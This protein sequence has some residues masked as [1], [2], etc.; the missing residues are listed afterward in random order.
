MS[1]VAHVNGIDVEFS[2]GDRVFINTDL[3]D[4][5]AHPG[6]ANES[7]KYGMTATIQKIWDGREEYNI[8]LEFDDPIRYGHN[9]TTRYGSGI[10]GNDPIKKSNSYWVAPKVVT[11]LFEEG[12]IHGVPCAYCGKI[13]EN[14]IVDGK[15]ICN[16]C[17]PKQTFV[18]E[19]CGDVHDIRVRMRNSQL[20]KPCFLS[21]GYVRCDHCSKPT[22]PS[23]IK[24]LDHSSLCPVCYPQI[25]KPC[26]KCGEMHYEHNLRKV[27]KK[28]I[29]ENCYERD[30]PICG[31]CGRRHSIKNTKTIKVDGAD[32]P[33]CKR[34]FDTRIT[35]CAGCG[36]YTTNATGVHPTDGEEGSIYCRKCRSSMLHKCYLCGQFHLAELSTVTLTQKSGW[37]GDVTSERVKICTSCKENKVVT[38][39]H[40][41]N[42]HIKSSSFVVDGL[43]YCFTCAKVLFPSC[44]YC[45]QPI[46][47]GKGHGT[48]PNAICDSCYA[49]KKDEF[50]HI[51]SAERS[52]WNYHDGVRSYGYKPAPIMFPNNNTDELH[53]GI[54]LEVDGWSGHRVTG[55]VTKMAD[56]VNDR[57][58][59]SYTKNDG[60]LGYG[61]FEIV[62]HPATLDYHVNTLK[63]QWI[64]V[65]KTLRSKGYASHSST[66]CGLHV[67]VSSFPVKYE[68]ENG[69]EKL[70]Y[71]WDHFWPELLK[72][73]RRNANQCSSWAKRTSTL[74]DGDDTDISAI[75]KLISTKSKCR[76]RYVA[77]NLNNDNTIEF[78]LMRGTLN[79]EAFFATLELIDAIVRVSM[80]MS[81]KDIRKM[82]W[83]DVLN[84]IDA[85]KYPHAKSYWDTRK[86]IAS[87]TDKIEGDKDN[88]PLIV[89]GTIESG[90]EES[91][92]IPTAYTSD[93]SI[94]W[95]ASAVI[96]NSPSLSEIIETL[97]S[98]N[99]GSV[100]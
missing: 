68:A 66:T 43:N 11:H 61:G 72:F 18:C 67:H 53:Y 12:S 81:F 42:Y 85:A 15:P 74:V 21:K 41:G 30:Y 86:N 90:V 36:E 79:P 58:G 87:D 35:K 10:Y 75:D 88:C 62:T 84:S 19:D 13:G 20:C 24:I 82:S 3:D 25:A 1:Y 60:S 77:V 22:L 52:P 78:R 59:Y 26:S 51:R 44:S 65:M 5:D 7:I 57:L 38:C 8:G 48:Y 92:P 16:D 80:A 54:E 45:G 93:H 50:A 83:D 98:I 4:R 29:C 94:S 63:D 40:C 37:G 69:V 9:L 55:N 14:K 97:A 89:S 34:C 6:Y 56:F 64:D 96:A 91:A 76:E 95:D 39:S 28:T 70:L 32:I 49:I 17:L 71:I 100:A 33:V 2:I 23:A 46:T 47:R 99:R 31:V 27:G 73:S